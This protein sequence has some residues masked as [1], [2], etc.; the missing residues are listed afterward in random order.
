MREGSHRDA[1]KPPRW[2]KSP[3]LGTVVERDGRAIFIANANHPALR[4]FGER[5]LGIADNRC[6]S[7]MKAA[8]ENFRLCQQIKRSWKQQKKAA[9]QE[10]IA[11][12]NERLARAA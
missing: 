1:D 6:D 12:L 10:R 3:V 9:Q 11:A 5:D 7:M 8:E 4:S 2:F